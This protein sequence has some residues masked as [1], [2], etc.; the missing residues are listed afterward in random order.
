MTFRRMHV[1]IPPQP[2]PS[3]QSSFFQS[4]SQCIRDASLFLG[5]SA[6]TSRALP[7]F[8]GMRIREE[9]CNMI[10]LAVVTS[11]SVAIAG[12]AMLVGPA[13]DNPARLA[14]R[15]T[16]PTEQAASPDK[17]IIYV[18]DA[19]PARMVGAPFVPNTNP[20]ER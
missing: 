6:G 5:A 17:R 18:T 7:R 16:G 19:P 15:T 8:S 3:F 13:D 12:G 10:L 1:L 11:I 20:R 14:E 2:G 4:A 9:N